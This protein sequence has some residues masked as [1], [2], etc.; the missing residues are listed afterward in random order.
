MGK[1]IAIE[2]ARARRASRLASE[3][4]IYRRDRMKVMRANRLKRSRRG[5][6]RSLREW[7]GINLKARSRSYSARRTNTSIK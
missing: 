3:E 5:F 7:L 6:W 1:C 2:T 4:Q